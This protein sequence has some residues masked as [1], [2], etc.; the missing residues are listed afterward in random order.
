MNAD[1]FSSMLD[2]SAA[3][4][5]RAARIIRNEEDDDIGHIEDKIPDPEKIVLPEAN[6]SGEKSW[7]TGMYGLLIN[8]SD[9]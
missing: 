3:R 9:L 8:F 6:S 5:E 7:F 2:H 1:D 4:L